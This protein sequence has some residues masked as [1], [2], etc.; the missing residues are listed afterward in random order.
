MY[1]FK[2]TK[3]KENY[4][5]FT[6]TL[7]KKD[8]KDLLFL[9]K[10]RHTTSVPQSAEIPQVNSSTEGP[11]DQNTK[12]I[13][14]NEIVN[15]QSL[16]TTLMRR[17]G[18]FEV[19]VKELNQQ[20]QQLNSQYQILRESEA[21]HRSS[22]KK[23]EEVLGKDYVDSIL[24]GQIQ[25][26]RPIVESEPRDPEME[27]LSLLRKRRHDKDFNIDDFFFLGPRK[28]ANEMGSE[29]VNYDLSTD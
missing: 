17:N 5:A 4:D 3:T 9:I 26:S 12:I 13:L 24:S 10:R 19:K 18:W 27:A 25:P 8:K 15:L 21:Q 29:V 23:L 2:K 6:H 1:G 16:N 11:T 20:L 22:M 28:V 14:C 7:F